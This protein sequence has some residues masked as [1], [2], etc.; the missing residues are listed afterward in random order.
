MKESH[1]DFLL[2]FN[3]LS[4]WLCAAPHCYSWTVSTCVRML[5]CYSA[6]LAAMTLWWGCVASS[7]VQRVICLSVISMEWNGFS[8]RAFSLPIMLGREAAPLL[9]TCLYLTEWW[10]VGSLTRMVPHAQTKGLHELAQVHMKAEWLSTVSVC[11]S[12]IV[13]T[14]MWHLSLRIGGSLLLILLF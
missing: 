7:Q 10:W 8:S 3:I 6:I 1:K 9:G 11:S 4:P 13:H 2:L 5:Y 12:T 14:E